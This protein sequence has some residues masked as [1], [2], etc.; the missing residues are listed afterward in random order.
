MQLGVNHV[1]N[2][3]QPIGFSPAAMRALRPPVVRH[4]VREPENI[5]PWIRSAERVRARVVWT[6]PIEIMG[7]PAARLALR[8]IRDFGLEATAGVEIG[9]CPWTWGTV[10][11]A[12]FLGM[13]EAV[14]DLAPRGLFWRDTRPLV[15]GLGLNPAIRSAN[16]W[17]RAFLKL[18]RPKA[19]DLRR[20][21][22]G[23][24]LF[25]VGGGRPFR[26]FG[27]TAWQHAI[28]N[29]LGLPIT[30]SRI[31]WQIGEDLTFWQGLRWSFRRT[32]AG[33]T[34]DATTNVTAEIRRRWLVEAFERA[35]A[36]GALQFLLEADTSPAS[37]NDNLWSLYTEHDGR[38]DHA[39]L[40]LQWRTIPRA[41]AEP[42]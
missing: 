9:L 27:C 41:A 1:W 3:K 30:F 35:R 14:Q 26:R 6:I 23:L 38:A 28:M 34:A 10:T 33:E 19:E 8:Q 15:I 22:H 7:V 17:T 40:A 25:H 12:A 29:S 5:L 21:Y 31:G 20:T 2:P 39:W 32:A 13:L 42:V 37:P 11:P 4:L 16:V 36:L 18:A 24:G